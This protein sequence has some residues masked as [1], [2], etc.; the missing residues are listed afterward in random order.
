MIRRK[1][2]ET[3]VSD[4]QPPKPKIETVSEKISSREKRRQKLKSVS[5]TVCKTN[6]SVY[7]IW[8]ITF[9]FPQV[10]EAT[11]PSSNQ[12]TEDVKPKRLSRDKRN[13][14]PPPKQ[15]EHMG[16]EEARFFVCVFL[17]NLQT[18]AG[19]INYFIR[20]GKLLIVTSFSLSF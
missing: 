5:I 6:H 20:N 1:A 18:R 7:F 9:D 17:K 8:C 11:V 15:M 14:P 13:T 4:E 3:E 12:F 2:V 19:Q 16:D 10:S